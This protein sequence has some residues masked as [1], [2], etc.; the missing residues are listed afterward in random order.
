MKERNLKQIDGKWLIDISFMKTDGKF[1]R[2]RGLPC[3]F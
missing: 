2:A 1:K 3:R